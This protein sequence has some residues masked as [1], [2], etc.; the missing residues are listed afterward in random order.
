MQVERLGDSRQAVREKALQVLVS[1]FKVLRP[2]LVFEKL[3]PYWQHRN[4]KVK[5]GL[6][7]AVA[8][9]VSKDGA[10]VLGSKD[11]NHSVLKQV[12]KMV[13]EPDV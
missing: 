11:Q 8:E 7:Q 4:W 1:V 6:L 3:T 2:E 5:H 9:A 13:E 10:S 12:I